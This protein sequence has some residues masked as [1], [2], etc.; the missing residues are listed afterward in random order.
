VHS[1]YTHPQQPISALF[2]CSSQQ[3]WSTPSPP[4][5]C[6]VSTTSATV[7]ACLAYSCQP[8]LGKRNTVGVSQVQVFMD[9]VIGHH[10]L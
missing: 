10:S 5:A 4:V 1:F 3:Q 7:G 9:L 8:Q 6:A 2:P